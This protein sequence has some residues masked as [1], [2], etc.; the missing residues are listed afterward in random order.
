MTAFCENGQLTQNPPPR[1][2]VSVCVFFMRMCVCQ[3]DMCVCVGLFVCVCVCI[4]G[5]FDYCYLRSYNMLLEVTLIAD[6][7]K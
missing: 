7:P 2:S 5:E 3:Q 6:K 4:C 1:G